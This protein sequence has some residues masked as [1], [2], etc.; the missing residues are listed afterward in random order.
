MKAL[1]RQCWAVGGGGICIESLYASLV[2]WG[3][4]EGVREVARYKAVNYIATIPEEI[5]IK[6]VYLAGQ[7]IVF[8]KSDIR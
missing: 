4:G 7:L 8:C 6:L 1:P 2:T 5:V 3:G